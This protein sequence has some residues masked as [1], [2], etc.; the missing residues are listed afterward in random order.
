MLAGSQE[1]IKSAI[2]A[3]QVRSLQKFVPSITAADVQRGPAGVRAQ[4]LDMS[5]TETAPQAP[6]R[7]LWLSGSLIEDFVFDM[8][9][10]QDGAAIGSRVLH[11][12]NAPSP[13]ATSSLAIARMMADKLEEQFQL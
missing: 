13:G 10:G 12:R 9:K 2:P 4:A 3:L 1:V 6:D 7:S 5:G 8:Y 11:C